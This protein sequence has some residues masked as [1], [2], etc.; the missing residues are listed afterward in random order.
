MPV[1]LERLIAE[2]EPFVITEQMTRESIMILGGDSESAEEK[3][4]SLA[5]R[6][7]ECL[8][9]SYRSI[10]RI[11]NLNGLSSLTKLQL[12]NN[13]I[14]KIE[15]LSHLIN[16]TWLDLS[17]NEISKI[18]GL[19]TLT[20]L[21]DLSLFNNKIELI[22]NIDELTELNVLSLGNNKI[23]KLDDKEK[24]VMYLRR[25]PNLRLLNL[26]GNP[27]CKEHNYRSYVLS[28]VKDLTYLDYRRVKPEHVQQ[29]M[30]QYQDE[31][32]ELQEVEEQAE[33][34]RLAEIKKKEHEA[35]MSTANLEG[36]ETLLKDMTEEDPEWSRFSLINGLLD[37]WAQVEDKV[38]NLNEPFIQ[39]IKDQ[40][41]KKKDE[42]EEWREV[43]RVYLAERDQQAKEL[44]L[45]YEKLKKTTARK[46]QVDPSDLEILN[47]PKIRLVQLKDELLEIEMD[48]VESL[49]ELVAEFD[50]N[51]TEIAEANKA[52]YN[53][54]FASIRDGQVN[55][56]SQLTVA[57]LALFEKYSQE[58]S[59]LENQPEE[60]RLLLQDKDQLVGALQ[61]S[62]D[63]HS[64]K[65]DGL[66]DRLTS[67]EMRA[68]N[69]LAHTNAM[70]SAKRNRDRISEIINY[71]E[72]NMY[73]LDEMAGEEEYDN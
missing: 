71:I 34:K 59:D 12:D 45:D 13:K 1:S 49:Q 22:E 46:L 25:F 20:K 63:A 70:W 50:R 52:I 23:S 33:A 17:F 69:D 43:V 48:T 72:R 30:E 60:A 42:Y 62:Q 8:A 3:K 14:V 67:K 37:G 31:M 15:N 54:Y 27:F 51:Y 16:L 58:N 36:I 35:E 29:A 28:H 55:F 61:A 66:E 53:T 6:D 24:N 18:E 39:S 57:A 9:Y 7:V 32:N 44:I 19:S 4:H 56:Y 68:A 65:V 21:V 47:H 73:E 41:Q 2:V 64:Q 11:D 38:A 5:L 10:A 40:H 26:A